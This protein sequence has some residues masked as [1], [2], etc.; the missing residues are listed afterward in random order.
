[1]AS[2]RMISQTTRMPSPLISRLVAFPLHPQSQRANLGGGNTAPG[3]VFNALQFNGDARSL[4]ENANGGSGDDN[5]NGNIANNTFARQQWQ[6]CHVCNVGADTLVGGAGNDSLVGDG[7]VLWDANA[8]AVRRL[9]IAT[10]NR[11]PDDGGHKDW[12]NALAGGQSVQQ[13]AT[14]FINSQEFQ[15]TYGT[16]PNEQFVTLLYNN[17]L[18]KRAPDAAGLADWVGRLNGGTSRE[19]VVVGF[20]ESQEFQNSTDVREHAGQIFRIYDTAFN[21]GLIPAGFPSGSM[22]ATAAQT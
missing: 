10:L 19:A 7:P 6:R 14:G 3:N 21:R 16:L 2:I 11:A 9:Y 22:R 18:M 15:N 8:A 1:M 13:I 5:I 20:S 12:T 17:V 4:I